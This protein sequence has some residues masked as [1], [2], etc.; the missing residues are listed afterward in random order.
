MISHLFIRRVG[1]VCLKIGLFFTVTL[2]PN[3]VVDEDGN[4]DKP[5]TIFAPKSDEKIANA[6]G[7]H[8]QKYVDD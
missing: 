4:E 2:I 5:A 8:D 7:D 6:E 3:N 1:V